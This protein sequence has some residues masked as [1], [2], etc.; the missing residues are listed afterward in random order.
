[1]DRKD[2]INMKTG[3]CLPFLCVDDGACGDDYRTELYTIDELIKMF[4][5]QSYEIGIDDTCN[6]FGIGK[7][8]SIHTRMMYAHARSLSAPCRLEAFVFFKMCYNEPLVDILREVLQHRMIGWKKDKRWLGTN[9]SYSAGDIM[10]QLSDNMA[11]KLVTSS[12][13]NYHESV[14]GCISRELLRMFCGINMQDFVQTVIKPVA[15]QVIPTYT[16]ALFTIR[17]LNGRTEENLGF[18][19]AMLLYYMKPGMDYKDVL[20][21]IR[22]DYDI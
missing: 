9:H 1:M 20:N 13:F 11:V 6:I 2:I 10:N 8:S 16:N 17:S 22:R 19:D 18:F 15:S 14:T 4:F 7:D 3:K 12:R 21:E 5:A